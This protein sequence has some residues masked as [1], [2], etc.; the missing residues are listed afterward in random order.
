MA[1]QRLTNM[2]IIDAIRRYF[3]HQN[4]THISQ[5][6]GLDRKTV[7]GHVNQPPRAKSIRHPVR[8]SFAM[9]AIPDQRVKCFQI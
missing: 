9:L 3:D 5:A 2:E 1:Y 8:T 6:T 7:K 4:I